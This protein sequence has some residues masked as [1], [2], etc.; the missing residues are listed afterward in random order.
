MAAKN[1]DKIQIEDKI[2]AKKILD[3]VSQIK[4]VSRFVDVGITK[5]IANTVLR[6]NNLLPG[7]LISHDDDR[8]TAFLHINVYF[9]I[10]IPQLSYDIQTKLKPA[11]SEMTT[12]KV[13]AINII[14]EGI[15]T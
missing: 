13:Q 15:D 1:N 2:L 10:N 9:G 8:I 3:E 11:L 6:K 12:N 7:I 5:S 14:V 4:G